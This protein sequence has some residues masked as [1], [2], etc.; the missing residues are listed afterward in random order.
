MPQT[1]IVSA[2]KKLTVV[3]GRLDK[4]T[5]KKGR[6][7]FVDYAHS[8]DALENVLTALGKLCKKRIFTVFGCGGDRDKSKRPLMGAIA[9]KLSSKIIITSDNPRTE[10][11]DKIISDIVVGLKDKNKYCVE[12]D[13]RTAIKRALLE[14]A[15]GDVILIAGKGHEDYQIIGTKK[16]HFSDK[17]TVK[18]ILDEIE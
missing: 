13:R 11:P 4:I 6:H 16:T 10:K 3:P 7:I 12:P 1:K 9:E 8:P 18:E 5:S 14:A 17:E 2:I 15:P